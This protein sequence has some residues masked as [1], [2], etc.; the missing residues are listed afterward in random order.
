ML[1][2]ELLRVVPYL[3]AD[4][5]IWSLRYDKDPLG[6]Y[7]PCSRRVKPESQWEGRGSIALRA[8]G[9]EGDQLFS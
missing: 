5:E 6:L 7:A 3:V 1:H 8:R 4:E 9:L 2:D